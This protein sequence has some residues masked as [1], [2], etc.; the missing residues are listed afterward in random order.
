MAGSTAPLWIR[1]RK[2]LADIAQR[3]GTE[4]G[5][6]KRVEQ[7]VTVGVRDDAV[8]M[9][10]AHA[11]Q[12]HMVARAKGVHIETE[13]HAWTAMKRVVSHGESSRRVNAAP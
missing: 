11:R 8:G 5:I 7:H 9:R 12:P 13:A 10:H 4:Q 2:M 3:H 1:V 6:A